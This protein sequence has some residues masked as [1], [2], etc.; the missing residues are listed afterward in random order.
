[1][2]FPLR[3][4]LA[5]AFALGGAAILSAAQPRT[6]TVAQRYQQLCANCHGDKLQGAQAGSLLDDVWTAGADD[7]A[8]E[9]SIRQ[10][11][12]EKGMPAW[13]SAIPD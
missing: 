1:M 8:I 11:F 3:A 12:P 10:G 2:I 7:A 6:G 9:R 4:P 5:A 13:G